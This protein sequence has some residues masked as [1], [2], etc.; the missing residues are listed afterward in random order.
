MHQ[1]TI[2]SDSKPPESGFRPWS[3]L[4]FLL[5]WSQSCLED[6]EGGLAKKDDAL[7]RRNSGRRHDDYGVRNQEHCL[8]PRHGFFERDD[9][10]LDDKDDGFGCKDNGLRDEDNG[11]N[12]LGQLTY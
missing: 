3:R 9:S 2:G 8:D 12:G 6:E 7:D 1:L 10:G 4:S 11:Q 5:S